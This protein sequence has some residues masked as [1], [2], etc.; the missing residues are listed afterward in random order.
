[1]NNTAGFD[2]QWIKYVGYM[3]YVCDWCLSRAHYH[4][5]EFFSSQFEGNS[6]P[7]SIKELY[8][9]C[10]EDG[11]R[12]C[13]LALNSY[14]DFAPNTG[15][16]PCCINEFLNNEYLDKEYM[17]ELLEDPALIE[18]YQTEQNYYLY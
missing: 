6:Y 2:C 3:L 12:N 7:N 13:Y 17:R 4:F 8:F 5:F 1:M 10:D 18:A 14:L 11:L 15:E 9:T 16:Y